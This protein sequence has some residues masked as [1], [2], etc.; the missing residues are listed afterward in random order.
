MT[1]GPYTL[2]LVGDGSVGKSSIVKA[3][4][5]DGFS[6]VYNQTLGVDFMEKQITLKK[7]RTVA[8]RVRDIG[9]QSISSSNIGKYLSGANAVWFV[10]DVTNKESFVNLYDWLT[11]VKKNA[12]TNLLYLLGNKIDL[13]SSRQVREDEHEN[14]LTSEDIRDG[15]YVSARSGE[16]L[17][18]NFY[19]I[20][21]DMAGI[22]LN[23]D[24]LAV[25][26]KVLQAVV[27]LGSDNEARTAFADQIEEEDRLAIQR[28]QA[29]CNCIV[30]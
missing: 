25:H 14:F 7:G 21:G 16:N 3:F 9:G 23:E 8:L 30:S 24:D 13:V 10:Y 12:Q 19:K 1:L 5:K 22:Q 29:G 27:A 11:I 2:A 4:V 20:A 6:P 18:R 17:M 26:D 15:M 28:A